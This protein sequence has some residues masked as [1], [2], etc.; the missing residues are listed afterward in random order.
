MPRRWFLCCLF[1][2][3]THHLDLSLITGQLIGRLQTEWQ[4]AQRAVTDATNELLSK[5]AEML[6]MGTIETAKEAE[7]GI[8]DLETLVKTNQDLID[9]IAEV[10]R[11]QSEAREQRRA[12]EQK[13]S[14]METEL[15]RKMLEG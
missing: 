2:K 6:K 8:I 13:L 11:I 9:T 12:A 14:E 10:Q 1:R 15:K 7:R 5:N 3:G 4:V